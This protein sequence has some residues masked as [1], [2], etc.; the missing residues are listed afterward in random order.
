MPNQ[1][2]HSAIHDYGQSVPSFWEASA[3]PLSL[4]LQPLE[5][6]VAA[7]VAIIGAGFTGLSAALHL[8]RDH[9]IRPVVLDAGPV[10][11]GA[12]GRNGGF[13]CLGSSKLSGPQIVARFGIEAARAFHRA[14]VEAIATVRQL[15]HDEGIEIEATGKGE[16][17]VAHKPERLAGLK[18]QA[19]FVA[20]THGERWPVLG[21]QEL[22]EGW[23]DAPEAHGA[24]HVPHGFGLHPLRYV[25][26]LAAAAVRHGVRLHPRS[27]VVGWTKAQGEHRLATAGGTVRARRV[28]VA[29]NGFYREGLTPALDGRLLPA[30]SGI[31]VTRPLSDRERLQHGWREPVLLADSRH[32]LF[33]IR[34]LRDGRLLFGARGGTDAS[35]AGFARRRAWMARRLK[36]RFPHWAGVEVEHAWWGLVCLVGDRLPHLGRLD[37]EPTVLFAGAYHGAGV[38]MGTWMGRAAARRLAGLPDPEDLPESILRAPP[39]FPLAGLRLWGLRLAYAGYALADE[40]R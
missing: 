33:Y 16:L 7:D 13:C 15:A 32:L 10:G 23:L 4:D 21:R 9:A 22:A 34:L 29:T 20:A 6:D 8:A 1:L 30:L 37:D 31:L 28:L 36:E 27:E 18:A 12:S 5:G 2:Y 39:R 25:R 19:E 38:A 14:Q 3:P 40:W 26:G 24:L 35:P 11:W 17:V